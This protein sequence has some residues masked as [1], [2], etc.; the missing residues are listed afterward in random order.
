MQ[1]NGNRIGKGSQGGGMTIGVDMGGALWATAVH[2]WES[3]KESYFALKDKGSAAKEKLLFGKIRESVEAGRAVH[4][5][6]EAGR[7]GYWV[8]REVAK[9]GAT[10]HVLPISKLKVLMC[11]K[12][13][14]TD[15]LDAKFLGGLHP[16]DTLPEV[17]IPTLEEEGC[18]DAEREFERLSKSIHRLNAQLIALVERT[19]LKTPEAHRTSVQWRRQLV[20]WSEGKELSKMSGMMALRLGNMVDELELA[21]RHAVKWQ[22]IVDAK[23]EA[24]ARSKDASRTLRA[25]TIRKLESFKGIGPKI[26]RFMAWELGDL[27]RF[28]NGKH[29]SSYLG[30]TPCPWASG[31]MNK[32]QGISKTGRKSLRR[33]AVEL[34]WLWAKWQ[35][36]SSLTRKWR[37]RLDQKGRSRR[38]AIVAMARQLMVALWRFIVKGEAIEGALIN[39]PLAAAE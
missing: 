32:D 7:Y 5:Y 3:G 11:G 2:D 21:E 13:V 14:K 39:K 36:G 16:T 6:Y 15:R 18:R 35:P 10:P 37:A 25:E 20:F 27:S 23:L 1:R 38:T 33:M 9:L 19:P 12:V 30:L 31:A 17:H 4:V 28:K 24:D 29:F 22:S 34:A 8:A 26:S